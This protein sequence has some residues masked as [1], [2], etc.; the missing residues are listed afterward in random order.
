MNGQMRNDL[1]SVNNG[2]LDIPHLVAEL[3]ARSF[4][5]WVKEVAGHFHFVNLAA[6][7]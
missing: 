2:S 4:C 1:V 5:R 3:F 6:V 7:D